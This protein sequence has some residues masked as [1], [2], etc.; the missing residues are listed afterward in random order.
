MNPAEIKIHKACVELCQGYMRREA[1]IVMQLQQ[2]EQTKL[3]KQLGQPSLFKY[4]VEICGLPEG[5]AYSFIAVG[6]KAKVHPCLK[7]ALVTQKLTVSKA[8]RIVSILTDENAIELVD[9]AVKHSARDIEREVRRRN[10]KA[11]TKARIKPLNADTDLLQTPIPRQTTENITTAQNL[12]A[13]KTSKH[14]GLSETITLVFKDYVDRHDPLRK[15]SQKKRT[16]RS[17]SARAEK[18]TPKNLRIKLTAEE[19]QI[20]DSRDERMCTHI[21]KNGKRCCEKRWLHYHHIKHVAHGGSNHPGN[22]TTLCSFHHDL[23]HQ[24][25]FPLEGERTWL[26][27]PQTSYSCE[28]K[29]SAKVVD[30][31][32]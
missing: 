15:R 32:F 10:P 19:K 12:L 16:E 22:I 26:R 25:V 9:F 31:F 3:F 8:Q 14:Q 18:P 2:V 11:A 20:V 29:F 17:D 13:Q 1:P 28:S 6:R 27:S 23:V 5:A 24:L 21:D 30:W 7:A 4:A